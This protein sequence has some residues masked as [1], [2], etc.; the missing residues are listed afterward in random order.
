MHNSPSQ[1]NRLR[2]FEQ[3]RRLAERCIDWRTSQREKS[4]GID[5]DWLSTRTSS[6]ANAIACVLLSMVAAEGG[7]VAHIDGGC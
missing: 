3:E 7:S 2:F 4:R 5:I 1:K 6:V